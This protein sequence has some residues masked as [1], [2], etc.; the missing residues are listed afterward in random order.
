MLLSKLCGVLSIN[1]LNIHDARIF[2]RK[3][4]IVIDSFAVTDFR[5][6]NLVEK[7]RYKK[8]EQNMN[9]VI[10]GSLQLTQELSRLKSKWWR[11]ENKFFKRAG[12]VKVVFEEHEKFSILDIFSPDRL[13]LLYQITRKMGELGLSIY[14]AKI[15]T[16]AD[17]VVDSFYLLDRNNRKISPNDYEFIK[18]ELTQAIEQIL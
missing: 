5:T 13:G 9:A 16:R 7:E 11:I 18:T 3:D 6:H 8:I 15:S 10:E 4:G 17:D 1:D 14:F 12:K 2:T